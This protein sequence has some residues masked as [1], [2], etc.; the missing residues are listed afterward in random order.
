M[1]KYFDKNFKCGYSKRE[2]NNYA[3]LLKWLTE[4]EQH[5]SINNTLFELLILSK[6]VPEGG[7]LGPLLNTM[8]SYNFHRFL[9]HC[10]SDI[11]V[12]DTQI[13]FSF[14]FCERV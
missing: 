14:N 8:Y 1:A 2:N 6:G 9:N 3:E 13:P 11:Y 4:V 10:Q 7:I 12:D 5:I